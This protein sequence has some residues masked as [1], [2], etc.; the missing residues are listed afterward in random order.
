MEEKNKSNL[1]LGDKL[2]NA[3]KSVALT[4]QQLA[5]KLTVSR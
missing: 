4:Q 5:E 2:K 1:T 3:R